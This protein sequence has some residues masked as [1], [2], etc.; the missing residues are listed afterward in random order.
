[1]IFQSTA[2]LV[3]FAH[4]LDFLGFYFLKLSS[5]FLRSCEVVVDVFEFYFLELSSLPGKL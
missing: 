1:M 4:V 5:P 2:G 3:G